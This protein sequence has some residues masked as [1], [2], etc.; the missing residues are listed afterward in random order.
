MADFASSVVLD[1]DFTF[2]QAVDVPFSAQT[3]N[4]RF[5][6][7]ADPPAPL[8]FQRVWDTVNLVWCYYAKT[9]IDTSPAANE[10]TPVHSGSIAN[11]NIVDQQ[12]IRGSQ[13]T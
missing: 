10:T 7:V 1:P 13:R 2:G 6:T 5:Y 11:H 12:L 4:T 3:G 8:I 9:R